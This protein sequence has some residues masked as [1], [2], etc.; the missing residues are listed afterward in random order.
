MQTSLLYSHVF[1]CGCVFDH[2]ISL[3]RT[4]GSEKNRFV[5]H[6]LPR[7][8][9]EKQC[10]LYFFF[11]GDACF[12]AFVELGDFA[13][14]GFGAFGFFVGP[15]LFDF[16]AFDGDLALLAEPAAATEDLEALF[17]AAEVVFFAIFFS[18]LDAAAAAAFRP[19]LA[20]VDFFTTFS[21]AAVEVFAGAAALMGERFALPVVVDAVLLFFFSAVVC[22]A[23]PEPVAANLNEPDAP[24]PFVCTRV[25]AITADFKYFLI[26]GDTFSASTL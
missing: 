22:L 4:C 7:N 1:Y 13:V 9:R 5:F 6:S 25:P 12:F 23:A 10:S 3:I 15:G 26:K 18:T 11:F 2:P 24:F 14:L 16:L 17:S 8:G 19:P 20:A 21:L